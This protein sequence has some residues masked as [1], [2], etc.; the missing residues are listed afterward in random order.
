MRLSIIFLFFILVAACTSPVDKLGNEKLFTLVSPDSSGIHFVNEI[1]EDENVNPLQYENSYNGGGVAIGDVNNDGFDDIYFTSNRK[2]NR[3]YLNHGN[4]RFEDVTQKAGVTGRISWST[5]V[6]MAD[7]NGDGL[8]DMYVCHSGNLPGPQ[9]AN[10]LFINQGTDPAGIPHFADSASAYHLADSAFSIQA[11]FFDYDLDGDLDMV[12]LNHSPVR[13]NN[14]DETSITYL[15]NKTDSL[16]GLKLYRN[17]NNSFKEVTSGSGIRNAR[18]NF[19]LG[20]S[21]SDINHDGYPDMYVSNDYLAPDCLYMNTGHGSFVDQLDQCMSVTSQFSMGNDIADINNDGWPDVYTLDM[22]PEDN[23]RQK[24]LFGNDN[25]ELFDLRMKTGLHAQYMR[26]MLQL[27]NGDGSFSEIGQLAG[28]SNTDWSWAPL[29]ADFDNDGWKDL[30]ISNG[31]LRDYTNMDFQKFMGEFLRDNQGKVQ[32]SNLLELV[33]KMPASDVRNYCF[34]NQG[35]IGFSDKSHDWG[36]D[37]VSNSNGAAYA[38]LD[39]DGDMDLVVNNINKTAFV[40]RNNARTQTKHHFLRVRLEGQGKNRFALGAKVELFYQGR[41]QLQEQSMT[42]GFQ[43]SVSPVLLFGTGTQMTVDSLVVTWPDKKK[44]VMVQVSCDRDVLLKQS[45]AEHTIQTNLNKFPAVFTAVSPPVNYV[46]HEDPV[47]DFKRQ[48]LL[49]NSLSYDGPCMAKGDLNG[50]GLDDLFIGGAAGFSGAVYLQGKNHA[51][52]RIAERDLEADAFH[53]DANALLFDANGDGHIDLFVASGGYDNFQPGDEA[54]Q[55]RL[56][57][58]DGHGHLKKDPAALPQLLVSSRAVAAGDLNGDGYPDLFLGS[59]VIPGRYPEPPASFILLNNGKGIFKEATREVC[60][61]IAAAGMFTCAAFADLDGDGKQELITA[62][63]WMPLQIWKNSKGKLADKTKD[64]LPETAHGWWNTLQ[65]K[66]INGDGRP[67]IVAGN[68]GYNCQWRA[69]NSQPVEMYYKDFDDNG[70]VDPVFCY[71]IHGKSYPYTGRDELLEQLSMMRTRFADY[72]SYSNAGITEVFTTEELKGAGKLDANTMATTVWVSNSSGKYQEKPLPAEA[73][74]AP[75]YAISINDFNQDGKMDLLLGGNRYYCRVK[76]GMN[77]SNH[78]QLFTGDGT[79][80]FRYVPQLR[81]GL[82]IKGDIRSFCLFDNLL[83]AGINSK[84][85][86]AYQFNNKE[87]C[88]GK[89]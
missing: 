70:A 31:Y 56:Y 25:F 5:G 38:D 53:E 86:Q 79:G 84:A 69:G 16:T 33:K 27:N 66:D 14:L 68:E 89:D 29:F 35:G 43:S 44:Q 75:V 12:L 39:N 45:D 9:R 80:T 85:V 58:N 19:N 62:G 72:S 54:L 37:A 34:Q 24:L 21:I 28:V 47:N 2:G 57:I 52:T 17:D 11:A 23:R 32:K 88:S 51:F 3:L 63:E 8:L 65:V 71:Y 1:K 64:F 81:S 7:V 4:F 73:Q 49:I 13:F 76:T 74:F 60:P 36:L 30:F 78:G 83:L 46:H 48:P 6:T 55:S 42:R 20:I 22:L 10:E 61:Q 67:D 18:L 15:M 82:N 77:E 59:R 26:N 40:Y 50:D 41:R 87:N